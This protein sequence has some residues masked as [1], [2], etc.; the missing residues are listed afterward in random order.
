[1]KGLPLAQAPA[2]SPHRS[3]LLQ[4]RATEAQE[5]EQPLAGTVHQGQ[6]RSL[7]LWV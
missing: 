4:I 6:T 3:P 1:M 2:F 5:V 7:Q